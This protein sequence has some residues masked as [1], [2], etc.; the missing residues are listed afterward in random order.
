MSMLIYFTCN[1]QNAY[2]TCAERSI[3]ARTEAE[4]REWAEGVG[5][6][7]KPDRDLCP[8]HANRGHR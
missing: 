4:A 6:Y 1:Q 7:L 3:P 5:W 8:G 2:G